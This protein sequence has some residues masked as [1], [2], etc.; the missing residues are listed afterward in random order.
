MQHFFIITQK[1]SFCLSYQQQVSLS[2]AL[3][4]FLFVLDKQ[5]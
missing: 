3:N 4:I 5:G 1:I 2:F